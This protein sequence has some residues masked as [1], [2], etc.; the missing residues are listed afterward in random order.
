MHFSSSEVHFTTGIIVTYSV[1]PRYT[2]EY[3]VMQKLL[4]LC[5]LLCSE[6]SVEVDKIQ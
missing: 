3:I 1:L 5:L 4:M 2:K 6:T